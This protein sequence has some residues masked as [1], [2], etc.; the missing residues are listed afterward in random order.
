MKSSTQK[1][2]RLATIV[3]TMTMGSSLYGQID[4]SPID[5]SYQSLSA[6]YYNL[7]D[8]Y[9]DCISSS[10]EQGWEYIDQIN[11]LNATI[12]SLE[13][14]INNLLQ[15]QFVSIN[16]PLEL[17]QGWNMF[18]YT[19]NDSINAIEAFYQISESIEIVKDEWG[20][21]YLPSWD[22][23]AIG[24]LKFGEGYQIK[25]I[26][27]VNEFSFC[28]YG[29]IGVLGCKDPTAFNYNPNAHIDNG[30]CIEAVNGCTNYYADNYDYNANVDDGSCII[31][32]CMNPNAFNYNPYATYEPESICVPIIFGCTNYSSSNYNT[33]ANTD[34]GSCLGC[35]YSWADNFD[36]NVGV[37]DGSCVLEGCMDLNAANY[38]PNVTN[39]NG[40]CVSD[41]SETLTL[42]SYAG[43]AGGGGAYGQWA[44]FA[45]NV[46]NLINV[47]DIVYSNNGTPYTVA[48]FATGNPY[49][50]RFTT[51]VA[52]VFIPGN[53]YQTNISPCIYGCLDQTAQ[54]YQP[55]ATTDNDSCIPGIPGCTNLNSENY[56]ADATYD[57]GT[58]I[59]IYGCT[60]NSADNYNNIATND[61]GSCI[62]YGCT[63]YNA[64]NFSLTSN[65]DDGS[66]IYYGCTDSEAVNYDETANVDDNS[67]EFISG[68]M[69]PNAGNYNDEATIN[70]DNCLYCQNVTVF[71]GGGY[72]DEYINYLITNNNDDEVHSG[73]A[74]SVD[75][76]LSDGSY[77]IILQST[78]PDAYYGASYSIETCNTI[79]LANS[80][81]LNYVDND[82]YNFDVSSNCNFISGC[83]NPSASNF[84]ENANIEDGSCIILGCTEY[85]AS[86][87][88][89][90]ANQ[91]DGSCQGC[92][93]PNAYNFNNWAMVDDN[94]CIFYGCMDET[95]GN[96]DP[97]ATNNAT[98]VSDCTETLILTSYGG[99]VGGAGAYGQWAWF[100]SNMWNVISVGD[101][102]YSNNGTPY[103][104]AGFSTAN[105]YQVIFTTSVAGVFI[106]GNTY[107]TNINPCSPSGPTGPQ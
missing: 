33:S 22:F 105:P 66:C 62:Y 50:V 97:N 81:P 44:W 39:D 63:D 67:C 55:L 52:G 91:D 3:M 68:C 41:C 45:V 46:S 96:Y 37:N 36:V 107:Q 87:Y 10:N 26:E 101:I 19:C 100:N 48:G 51:I 9:Q 71:V 31:T 79:I 76:C 83:T 95:A 5:E 40:I 58:C 17:N 98:C 43:A 28:N 72:Y 73:S 21:S 65:T 1:L 12:S 11:E 99:A 2:I 29:V 94:S 30:S 89:Q 88:N 106:P 84:N 25:L 23:N 93:N 77:N 27:S 4:W 56:N 57:N 59:V 80:S 8:M 85:Y 90:N 24:S 74:G 20:L 86:N 6:A 47:G 38:N 92:T 42:T 18:G 82:V 104:V 49:Q 35:T 13:S 54:N 61:D 78:F 102:V 60:N 7:N 53:T 70:D 32:G 34:D 103:T 75:L 14:E 16:I 69:D 15:N 64:D